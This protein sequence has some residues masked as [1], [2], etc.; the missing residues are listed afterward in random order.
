MEVEFAEEAFHTRHDRGCTTISVS[1]GIP[2]II[3]RYSGIPSK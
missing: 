3:K 1:L 2:G